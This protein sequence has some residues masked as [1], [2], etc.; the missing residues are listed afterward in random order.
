M[1]CFPISQMMFGI[2]ICKQCVLSRSECDLC[3]VASVNPRPDCFPNATQ[4][5]GQVRLTRMRRIGRM[6]VG[7][8]AVPLILLA[9]CVSLLISP[10]V[11][12]GNTSL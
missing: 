10:R 12:L 5:F 11:G 7:A 2:V 1:K 4:L 9:S 3:N 8:A 6:R